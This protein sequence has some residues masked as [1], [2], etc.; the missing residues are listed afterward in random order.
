LSWPG[1]NVCCLEYNVDKG[2]KLVAYRFD[3]EEQL[4][5]KKLV[6][7]SHLRGIIFSFSGFI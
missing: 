7:G 4:S 1:N 5:N 2:G 6:F 3:G